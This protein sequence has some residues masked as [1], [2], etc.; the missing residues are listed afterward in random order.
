[1]SFLHYQIPPCNKSKVSGL[2]TKLL[3]IMEHSEYN[4]KSILQRLSSTRVLALSTQLHQKEQ[5]RAAHHYAVLKALSLCG[6]E[7]E[8]RSYTDRNQQ[9]GGIQTY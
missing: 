3:S 7:R 9:N 6:L 4:H 1:M 8:A 2:R 5:V